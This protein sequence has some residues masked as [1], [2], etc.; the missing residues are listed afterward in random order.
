[1]PPSVD[2]YSPAQTHRTRRL[3]TTGAEQIL[4]DDK[5]FGFQLTSSG[6]LVP[7]PM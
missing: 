3:W 6:T 1:M 5:R 2:G 7:E 4:V